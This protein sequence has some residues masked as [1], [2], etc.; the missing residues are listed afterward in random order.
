LYR[1]R[2]LPVAKTYFPLDTANNPKQTTYYL[3]RLK[4]LALKYKNKIVFT[5][6]NIRNSD[7]EQDLDQLGRKSEKEFVLAIEDTPNQKNYLFEESFNQANLEKFFEDFSE[8]KLSAH[9]RSEKIPT[10]EEGA[11]KTVVGKTFEQI[12][13]DP[14]KDV[15]IE[16]YAPWCG[17][18]KSLAPKFESLAKKM[19]KFDSVVV[20]KMD[21]TAND[22]DRSRFE[23]KGY[24]T[25]FFVPAKA[26][27]KPVLY[28]GERET[29]DMAKFIKKKA[30]NKPWKNDKDE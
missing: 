8:G 7:F 5:M 18:C 2:G 6:V 23:V 19:S 24:P 20:A 27:A 1:N 13:N 15:M 25:I 12:V 29:S 21:A 3:N 26:G 4:K 11:V 17:H 16:F 30:I 14:T 10:K 22:F 28:E 9:V